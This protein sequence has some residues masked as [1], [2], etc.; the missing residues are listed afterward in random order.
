MQKLAAENIE[1]DACAIRIPVVQRGE[2]G[3][4]PLETATEPLPGANLTVLHSL[5]ITV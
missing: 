5:F 4:S 3:T 2:G 1:Y